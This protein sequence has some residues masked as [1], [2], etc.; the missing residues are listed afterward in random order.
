MLKM[1]RSSQPELLRVSVM[2]KPV[3][4]LRMSHRRPPSNGLHVLQ[5]VHGGLS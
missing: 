2:G 3:A 5:Q 1:T 4:P